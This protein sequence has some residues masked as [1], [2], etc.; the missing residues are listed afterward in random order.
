MLK[1]LHITNEITKKNF[2]I[3]S[4]INYISNHGSKKNFFKCDVLCSDIDFKKKN[5]NLYISK[6]RWKNFF[7]LKKIFLNKVKDY[8]VV[9]IHGMWAPIQLYSI[10]LCLIYSKKTLIHPHGMLLYPAIN[11]N[12]LIKRIN[13]RFFLYILKFLFFNQKNIVFIAI[14]KEEYKEIRS[15]F[16]NLK[17]KLIQNNIPF[18]YLKIDKKKNKLEKVF[19]FFGRIHPHKNIIE[20]I[21]NF[22]ES[23]LILHGWK[24]EI[25]GIPDDTIY[26]NRINKVIK[27]YP[28]IKILDPVFGQE[29]IRIINRSWANI[30][31]SK[32]EVLSFSILE[33]GVHGLPSIVTN[34]IETLKND[35]FSQKVRDKSKHITDKLKFI[36]DWSNKKRELIGNKTSKFFIDY[37]TK[38]DEIFIKSLKLNYEQIF[39]QKNYLKGKNSENF[40]IASLV[41]SLNVFMP[42]IILLLSFFFFNS[43]LAAEIGL[44]NIVFITLTQMLSGNIRLIAIRK[45]NIN[46]LQEHLFFRVIV[47]LFILLLYQFLSGKF[48]FLEDNF[49]NLIISIFI[50]LLW[51]S[52]LGLTIFEIQRSIGKLLIILS[53]YILVLIVLIISFVISDILLMRYCILFSCILLSVFCFRGIFY[54]R[55]K[56]I[57]YKLFKYFF[58]DILKYISSLSFSLSSFCWRFYLYFTYPKE[59]SGAIF[60]A[61]AICSFPGTFFNNV[62][63]PNFFYNRIK[64]NP[65]IKYFFVVIFGVLLAYN[66]IDF[67]IYDSFNPQDKELFYHVLKISSLGSFLMFYAMYSRQDLVFRKKIKLE[68]LFYKDIGYGL[69]LIFILPL[70]DILGQIGFISYSY[71]IGSIFAIIIFKIKYNKPLQYN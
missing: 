22:I 50:I 18:D 52:E 5:K 1:I 26:L 8:D 65:K 30:L 37:K 21:S 67:E 44:T 16:V 31:I 39:Y 25:Y 17:V 61:F 29:K 55:S 2:S 11:H 46:F 24:L 7:E 14:T 66:V 28:Q 42:N 15:L 4:L 47:G 63:G 70:L 53:I 62:L 43:K 19:V 57:N 68:N 27:H 20:M 35:T 48:G 33:S 59:I 45:K 38:S 34:K 36:A 71:L 23:D 49:T 3:S 51:C 13:K 64:I 58:K 10:I 32:S 41:H 56:I 12:G 54:Q 9:H 60:I 6:I 40:Y 69:I